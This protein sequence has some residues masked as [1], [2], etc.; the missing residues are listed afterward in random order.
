VLTGIDRL[1]AEAQAVVGVVWGSAARR[2]AESGGNP[3]DFA[4]VYVATVALLLDPASRA[5]VALRVAQE[6]GAGGGD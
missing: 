5:A 1:P 3:S 4:Q 6:R 2:V